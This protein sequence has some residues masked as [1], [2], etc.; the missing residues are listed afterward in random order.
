TDVLLTQGFTHDIG[1][2]NFGNDL[3]ADDTS[4]PSE[5]VVSLAADN[6]F[7]DWNETIAETVVGWEGFT[8]VPKY[9]NSRL[10]LDGEFS[11]IGYDTNKQ[12]RDLTVYPNFEFV[13]G[14]GSYG[15]IVDSTGTSRDVR[16]VYNLNQDRNS[17][18]YFLRGNY[19]FNL[20]RTSFVGAA[21]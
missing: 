10:K 5:Q 21:F 2:P 6:G 11:Y 20:F 7:L 13:G 14:G 19:Q 17:Q 1:N 12:N 4:G 9:E 16:D 8:L 18:I 15:R 3:R